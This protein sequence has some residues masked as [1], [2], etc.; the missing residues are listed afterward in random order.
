MLNF[1]RKFRRKKMNGSYLK[2]ALGEIALVVFGILIAL[3]INN[4]NENRKE[5]IQLKGYLASIQKNLKADI[6]SIQIINKNYKK[7]SSGAKLFMEQLLQDIYSIEGL[8]AVGEVLG[9]EYVTVDQSGFEA[10]KNSGYISKLQGTD[11]EDALFKYYGHYQIVLRAEQSYNNFVERMEAN[12][13]G[14]DEQDMIDANKIF[15]Q[16]NYNNITPISQPLNKLIPK[17]ST[18]SYLI[19]MMN[20]AA[21]ED[22]DQYDLLLKY[23]TELSSKIESELNDY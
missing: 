9:E 15:N 16:P 20:R 19:G 10:L 14:M 1:L 2:Y 5:D 23:A 12:L 13:Y 3:A 6:E 21:D 4:W 7:A 18:N 17:L 11:I 8:M 22:T